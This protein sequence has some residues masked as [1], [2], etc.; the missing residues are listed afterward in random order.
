VTLAIFDLD[1]TLIGGDSDHLWGQFVCEQGFVDSDDF[2]RRGDAF[3]ADYEAGTLDIDAYLRFALSPLKGRSQELLK[4]WHQTFMDSK[5]RPI[6]LPAATALIADHRQRGHELLIV[7]ATNRFI[8]EPIARVL[9]IE[10]LIACEGEIVDGYYTGEPSGVP[11]FHAGKVTRLHQWL[12]GRQANL[13]GTWF[14]S[15]SHNDL[16]LLELVDNPVA[17][18][19][20]DTLRARALERGWPVISLR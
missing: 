14:Y 20:D 8:T 15:D 16:P 17:V 3:Y 18:D 9:G 13:E 10:N 5:I 7:T 19:P 4:T 6:L 1:N 11:S 12:E 2:A